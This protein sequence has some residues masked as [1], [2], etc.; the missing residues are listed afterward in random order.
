[1]TQDRDRKQAARDLAGALGVSY[2]VAARKLAD[3][4]RAEA[5]AAREE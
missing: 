5:T 2:S 4:P 3:P 1:M